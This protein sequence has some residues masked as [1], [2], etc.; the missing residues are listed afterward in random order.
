MIKTGDR[1]YFYHPSPNRDEA[2]KYNHRTVRAVVPGG[3]KIY[4][5]G[6]LIFVPLGDIRHVK[7]RHKT[8]RGNELARLMYTNG[9]RNEDVADKSG[10]AVTTVDR[11]RNERTDRAQ[12][13]PRTMADILDTVRLLIK[14]QGGLI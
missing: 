5:Y 2:E 10:Y 14:Q 7:R 13:K 9:L 8:P 1:V 11:A 4:H 6:Q 12:I 3:L